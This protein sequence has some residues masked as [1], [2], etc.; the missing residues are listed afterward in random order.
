M[1][2]TE[3]VPHIVEDINE[4]LDF[5]EPKVAHIVSKYEVMNG[6]INGVEVVALCGH[7]FIP[8]RD[9]NKFPNCES[10]KDMLQHMIGDL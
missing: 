5:E 10:C 6:Y 9:P 1:S 3:V 4:N 2:V 7:R 8:T